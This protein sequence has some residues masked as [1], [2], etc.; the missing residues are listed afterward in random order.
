M[1]HFLHSRRIDVQALAAETGVSRATIYRWFGSRD[2]LIGAAMI[3]AFMPIMAEARASTSRRGA[4]ALA[5]TFATVGD[6]LAA[7]SGLSFFLESEREGALRIVTSSDGPIQPKIVAMVVEIIE[8]EVRSGLYEP[9]VEIDTLA[10]ATVRVVEAFLYNDAVAGIS[11]QV[12][13]LRP[14]LEAMFGVR[15]SP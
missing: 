8:D 6:L 2:G 9:P 14:M 11:G 1:A 4:A 13:R 10:Y 5:D 7:A 15:R 12:Y 3:Q